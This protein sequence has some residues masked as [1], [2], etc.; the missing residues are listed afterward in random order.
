MSKLTLCL[1][2]DGVIHQ[3]NSPWAGV[4]VIPD[5]VVPGFFEW[6][7]VAAQHFQL[8]IYSARSCEE[9]GR[10]AMGAWLIEQRRKWREAGG[11]SPVTDGSPVAFDFAKEKPKAF[12]YI[13]DRAHHFDGDWTKLTPEA[14]RAFKPWNK[15]PKEATP[16]PSA[17]PEP[18]DEAAA[19]EAAHPLETGRHDLYAMA[20]RLVGE[21]HEKGDLVD[22][23]NWL[24]HREARWG[25]LSDCL[26][27][28]RQSAIDAFRKISSMVEHD[29]KIGQIADAECASL[30]R[31]ALG[32]RL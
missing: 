24:L 17:A 7:D 15:R 26:T 21:R 25:E 29:S 9:K 8:V 30:A 18:I 3:Y 11:V 32:I 20:M 1:D 19:I 13:D 28:E 4:D 14:I 5:D 27:T 16:M 10:V 31:Y 6:A 12:L 2:F 23:V 22:L